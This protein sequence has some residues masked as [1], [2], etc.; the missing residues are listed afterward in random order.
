MSSGS[1]ITS[2]C[3]DGAWANGRPPF[4]RQLGP[5]P[6]ARL[7]EGMGAALAAGL[8]QPRQRNAPDRR[9]FCD[10]QTPARGNIAAKMLLARIRRRPTGDAGRGRE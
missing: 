7:S 2:M 9:G 5:E 8:V 3:R 4:A 6:A 10:A 1:A